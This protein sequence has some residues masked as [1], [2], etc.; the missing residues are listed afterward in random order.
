MV[1]FLLVLLLFPLVDEA[2]V[3]AVDVV[4]EVVFAF[5]V[6]YEEASTSH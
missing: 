3:V 4:K 6:S 5:V 2:D 1:E